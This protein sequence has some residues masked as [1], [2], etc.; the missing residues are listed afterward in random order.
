MPDEP[1]P[2]DGAES[3]PAPPP[4]GQSSRDGAAAFEPC[5]NVDCDPLPDEPDISGVPDDPPDAN[6]VAEAVFGVAPRYGPPG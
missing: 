2:S 3:P 6:A 4:S 1:E 5:T